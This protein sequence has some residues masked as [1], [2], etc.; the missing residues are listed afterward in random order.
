[1][2]F[3]SRLFIRNTCAIKAVARAE[4]GTEALA[5]LEDLALGGVRMSTSLE[6]PLNSKV[7]LFSVVRPEPGLGSAEFKVCWSGHRGEHE[8]PEYGL[9]FAGPLPAL[10]DSWLEPHFA[11]LGLCSNQIF[12]RRQFRRY[13]T[14]LPAQLTV[15]RKKHHVRLTNLS[16][17]GAGI[18]TETPLPENA[19]LK[20][21]LEG[22]KTLL[23]AVAV[24]P[25]SLR[26][27][28]PAESVLKLSEAAA[29]PGGAK[30]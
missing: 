18:Q 29:V 11:S 6:L 25:A 21:R 23:S 3:D 8:W 19:P 24:G 1:M 17:G 5:L 16:A 10:L 28:K 20:L 12:E 13:P 30:A 27:E 22:E 7:E 9:K 26:F 4:D 14:D 2:I 15:R